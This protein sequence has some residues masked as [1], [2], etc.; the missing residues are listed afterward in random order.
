MSQI[1]ALQ[2]NATAFFNGLLTRYLAAA[3]SADK[4]AIIAEGTTQLA[5]YDAQFAGILNSFH[6]Q[7]TANGYDTSIIAT[8]QQDYNSQKQLAQAFL[9]S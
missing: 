4:S 5:Q 7:L 3:S 6:S 9:G 8:Y 2:S 1:S